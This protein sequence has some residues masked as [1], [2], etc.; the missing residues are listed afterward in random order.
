ML[1]K[2]NYGI[3]ADREIKEGVQDMCN[4]SD[5]IEERGIEK[6]I[7]KGLE[8]GIEALVITCKSLHCTK[9]DTAK[10]LYMLHHFENDETAMEKVNLYW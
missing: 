3:K 9:E 4:L 8:K 1:L 7:E 10:R 6:G 5:V 2:D